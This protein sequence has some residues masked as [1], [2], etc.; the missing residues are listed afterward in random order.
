MNFGEWI[1][2]VAVVIMIYRGIRGIGDTEIKLIRKALIKGKKMGEKL[3]DR[4]QRA[5]YID[6]KEESEFIVQDSHARHP[7]ETFSIQNSR[8]RLK[9]ARERLVE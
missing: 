5:I 9:E 4:L 1:I 7:F 8:R 3:M 6:E 2:L